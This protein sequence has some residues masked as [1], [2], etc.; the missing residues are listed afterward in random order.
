MDECV[1]YQH[2]LPVEIGRYRRGHKTSHRLLADLVDHLRQ[3]AAFCYQLRSE[4]KLRRK[5]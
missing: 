3:V 5:V 4:T 2:Y 1:P